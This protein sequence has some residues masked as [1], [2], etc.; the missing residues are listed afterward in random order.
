VNG[1]NDGDDT[2]TQ[3]SI[4]DSATG[5]MI[6]AFLSAGSPADYFDGLI[7]EVIVW[8]TALTSTEVAKVY[9]IQTAAQYMNNASFLFNFI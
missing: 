1:S 2:L 4:Y 3:T 7:D 6:G 8:N 5:F 9:S